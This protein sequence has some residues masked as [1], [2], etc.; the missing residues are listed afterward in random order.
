MLFIFQDIIKERDLTIRKLEQEFESLNFRNQQ[1][2]KKVE[3]LQIELNTIE[4]GKNKV[5]VDSVGSII[6]C[7]SLQDSVL[8][9]KWWSS[10]SNWISFEG[11]F[12]LK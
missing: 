9:N 10:D 8:D 1:L 7:S 5:N 12:Q 3:G 6:L 2:T 11:F 4:R